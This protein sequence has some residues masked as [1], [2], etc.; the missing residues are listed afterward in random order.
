MDFEELFRRYSP[1]VARF[2]YRLG[3]SEFD[4]DDMVQE[5]FLVAHRRGGYGEGT[6]TPTTYLGAICVR[7]TSTYRRRQVR[8]RS[9]RAESLGLAAFSD[10]VRTPVQILESNEALVQ[11]Q[12]A[13][14]KLSPSMRSVLVLADIEGQSCLDIAAALDIALGTVYWRLNKARKLF[15]KAV[16]SAPQDSLPTPVL[17]AQGCEL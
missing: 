9:L 7:A 17:N 2:L 16:K 10:A 12:Q 1:F 15:E 5:V 4:I 14:N 3:V 6:A 13:L 11:L 8:Y